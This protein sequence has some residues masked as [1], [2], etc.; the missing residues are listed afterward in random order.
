MQK[1]A[2]RGSEQLHSVFRAHAL[3]NSFSNIQKGLARRTVRVLSHCLKI[4]KK[5]HLKTK[6]FLK[7]WKPTLLSP[8]LQAYEKVLSG[9]T[10]GAMFNNNCSIFFILS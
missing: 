4:N 6:Q 8:S 2:L 9:A 7:A 3:R 10:A 5:K 1:D